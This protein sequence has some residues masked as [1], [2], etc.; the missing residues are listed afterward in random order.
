MAVYLKK[1][2]NTTEHTNYTRSAQYREPYASAISDEEVYFNQ[3]DTIY[4]KQFTLINYIQNTS[5]SYINTKYVPNINTRIEVKY[6]QTTLGYQYP[7]LFGARNTQSGTER[8][9]QHI[10]S[11]KSESKNCNCV[12]SNTTKTFNT[13]T[14]NN[15][16]TLIQC[17]DYVELDGTKIILS[18]I[19]TINITNSIY[20]FCLHDGGGLNSSC[21]FQ[22]KLFYCK[23][24]DNNI[25]QQYWVPAKVNS[26]NEFG[27]YDYVNKIF[28]GSFNSTKFTGG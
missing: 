9:Y 25:L 6:V 3:Y 17:K 22:G 24:Y 2:N 28:Y 26:T 19:S 8:F 12:V 15:E 23:I 27:M 1:F 11:G 14:I 4:G 20:L 7:T 21:F 18:N 10:N 16:H 5:N 13:S